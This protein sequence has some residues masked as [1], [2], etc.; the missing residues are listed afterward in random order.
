MD[1]E[2][3]VIARP[4]EATEQLII[5]IDGIWHVDDFV[6]LFGGMMFLGRIL[7]FCQQVDTAYFAKQY[8]WGIGKR[9]RRA[10]LIGELTEAHTVDGGALYLELPTPPPNE[11]ADEEEDKRKPQGVGSYKVN[12]NPLRVSYIY[13]GSP[14][15][16]VLLGASGILKEIRKFYEF[17]SLLDERK[18]MD[19]IKAD[20]ETEKLKKTKLENLKHSIDVLKKIGFTEEDILQIVKDSSDW[21]GV[22]LAYQEQSKIKKIEINRDGPDAMEPVE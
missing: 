9:D 18:K 15:K 4:V 12:I 14:G 7:D 16:I 11:E 19:K 13:Y 2:E 3:F 8:P 21:L 20:Q 10:A 22:F 1:T 6:K 17:R 5:D